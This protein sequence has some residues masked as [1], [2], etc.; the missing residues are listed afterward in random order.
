MWIRDR[1]SGNQFFGQGSDGPFAAGVGL[2]RPLHE[3]GAFRVVMVDPER[4][5]LVQWAFEAYS[6]GE[7][8]IRTLTEELVARGLTALPHGKK[9]P[10]PVQPSHVAHMLSN[11]YYLGYVTFKGVEYQGRHQPLVPPSMYDS[12]QA[13]LKAHD[14]SGEKTRVH[15]HY[16]KGSIFC[17]DCGSRLCFT[18]AK[19]LYP[20]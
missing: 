16:L 15:H 13:V 2:E 12:V 19:G 4:A 7:W 17:G 5:Q 20:Y 18:L 9:L 8:T 6:S 10:G 11:R 3:P 1:A 14:V